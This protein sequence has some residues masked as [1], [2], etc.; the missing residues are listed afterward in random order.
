MF[1]L[2]TQFVLLTL[3][4]ASAQAQV[5]MED[6]GKRLVDEFVDDVVTFSGTFEQVLLDPEGEVLERTNGT[7]EISRPARRIVGQ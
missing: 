4:V 3:L 2:I 7:L 5:L 1:R 6:A